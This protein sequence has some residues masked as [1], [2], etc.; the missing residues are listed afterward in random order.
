[1]RIKLIT[2][3]NCKYLSQKLKYLTFGTKVLPYP[4]L[5]PLARHNLG[6]DF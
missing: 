4:V 3:E 5:L 2:S 1:V 6:K